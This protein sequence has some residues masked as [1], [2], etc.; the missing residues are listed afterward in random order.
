ML[1]AGAGGSVFPLIDVLK[2]NYAIGQTPQPLFF[3]QEGTTQRQVFCKSLGFNYSW[4]SAMRTGTTPFT[5]SLQAEDPTIYGTQQY[6]P[7]GFCQTPNSVPG[8]NWSRAWSYTWGG[9]AM[10]GL[11]QLTNNGN[12]YTGFLATIQGQACQNPQ[13]I[14]DS[15]NG[16]NVDTSLVIGSTDTLVF[17]FYNQSLYLNGVSKHALV[18]NE[19]WFKL[20]PGVNVVR[21]LADSN[22]PAMITYTFY[23]GWR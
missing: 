8:Y 23:D 11:T 5:I 12:K 7:V 20:Q 15:Q 6:A 10:I 9:A 16:L 19:G 21:F 22:T 18:T 2:A 17:D 3:Q 14:C 13:I 1:Y 4:T